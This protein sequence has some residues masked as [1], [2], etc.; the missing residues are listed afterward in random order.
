[1]YVMQVNWSGIH[2]SNKLLITNVNNILD[3]SI[4]LNIEELFVNFVYRLMY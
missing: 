1:M 4:T 2:I 3:I